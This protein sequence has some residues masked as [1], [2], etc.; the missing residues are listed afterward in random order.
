[1]KETI[2]AAELEDAMNAV[3]KQARKMEDSDVYEERRHGFGM[4]SALTALAIYLNA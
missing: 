2:T 3:L 4:E 1:M